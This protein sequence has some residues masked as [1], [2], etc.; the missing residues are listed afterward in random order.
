MRV[1]KKAGRRAAGTKL[2]VLLVSMGPC[3]NPKIKKATI[4]TATKF[5][6]SEVIVSLTSPMALR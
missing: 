1:P 2:A 3:Q 6:S 4:L 5:N